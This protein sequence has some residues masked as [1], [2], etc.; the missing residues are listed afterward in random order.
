MNKGFSELSLA[1]ATCNLFCLGVH[2]MG[3]LPTTCFHDYMN[4]GTNTVSLNKIN[5]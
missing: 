2:E 1:V 5:R 4:F 3:E